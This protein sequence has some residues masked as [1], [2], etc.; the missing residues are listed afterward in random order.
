MPWTCW[1]LFGLPS[2]T[3]MRLGEVRTLGIEDAD[4]TEAIL[5]VRHARTWPQPSA[6]SAL[7]SGSGSMR[8]STSNAGEDV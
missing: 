8:I 1:C 2:V 5:T 4:L 7:A 3:G 6:A